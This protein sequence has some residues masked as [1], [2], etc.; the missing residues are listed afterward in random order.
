MTI[1]TNSN[2]G[3]IIADIHVHPSLKTFLFNKKSYKRNGT[4]GAWN[5]FA[6]RVDLPKIVEG[7][8]NVLFSSVYL[9]EKKM[10]MDCFLLR[11][12]TS[13]LG[14]KFRSLKKGDP[15]EVTMNII[16]KYE[17]AIAQANAKE[18]FRAEFAKSNKALN[19]ILE[20][21]EFA[22]LHSIEGAHSLSGKMENLHKFFDKGVCLL[23]LA[24]FYE[25]E[26]A[27]TVGGIPDSKKMLGCFKNS[28]EQSEGLPDF[29]KEV[30]EE[31]LRIGMLVD[32]SHCT[33]KARQE[34]FEMNN[35]KR[36]LI[37]SHVGVEAMNDATMN[38]TDIE[39]KQIANCG[40]VIG[41]IFMNHWLKNDEQ[42]NGLDL[43]VNTI[44]HLKD[45]GGVEC[46]AIGS[47]FDGFTDPP[48]DIKDIS[49]IPKLSD[50][51]KDEKFSND[52]IEKI[53]GTNVLRV[54]KD[55]WGKA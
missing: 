50:K 20:N 26:V 33:K 43:I 44:K 40:G 23:T 19:K 51:L 8:V 55:G 1:Q 16:L 39:I 32:F 14:K 4:G 30:V 21:K 41:V 28:I 45:K 48:D 25:N 46:I 6:M 17:D 13:I 36:P 24:H 15:F 54:L 22:I 10:I 3:P 5:P 7:G 53:M 27:R 31:M 12:A 42:K 11:F 18:N 29:G 2:N 34:I 52:E 49:E 37:F 38:P 35:N 47:D 9:P